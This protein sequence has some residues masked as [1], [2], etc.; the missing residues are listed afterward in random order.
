[1]LPGACTTIANLIAQGSLPQHFDVVKVDCEGATMEVLEGFG[2]YLKNVKVLQIESET[3]EFWRGQRLQGDVFSYIES[4]PFNF[5][6]VHHQ[7]AAHGQ[8]DSIFANKG[9]SC[10]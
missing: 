10:V 2:D 4:D 9:L 3:H 6:L 8:F 5:Q 1:M 7:Q